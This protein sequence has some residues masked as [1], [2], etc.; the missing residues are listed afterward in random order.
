MVTVVTAMVPD[1]TSGTGG[2]EVPPSPT[3]IAAPHRVGPE[4]ETALARQAELIAALDATKAASVAL[5]VER[6]ALAGSNDRLVTEVDA[7]T[8]EAAELN[9]ELIAL[10]GELVSVNRSIDDAVETITVHNFV[11]MPTD[12]GMSG[13]F[14]DM[15]RD[16]LAAD[17]E[18]EQWLPIAEPNNVSYDSDGAL[19]ADTTGA[20]TPEYLD[21]PASLDLIDGFYDSLDSGLPFDQL[22]QSLADIV[23][24]GQVGDEQVRAMQAELAY[25]VNDGSQER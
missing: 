13:T 7:L 9:R 8:Q 4:L 18:T 24:S 25:L 12:D 17:N 5:R 19:L 23:A 16:T 20:D 3:S 22:Q 21:D 14:P 6:D 1:T 11:N 10:E 2:T 15:T